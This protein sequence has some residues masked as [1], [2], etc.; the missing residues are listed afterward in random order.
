MKYL[1]TIWGHTT[2]YV[3]KETQ[4]MLRHFNF[5]NNIVDEKNI[6]PQRIIYFGMSH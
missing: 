1:W 5:L 6:E 2:A 4:T 3:S